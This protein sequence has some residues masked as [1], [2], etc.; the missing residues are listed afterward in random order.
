MKGLLEI[1]FFFICGFLLFCMN[2]IFLSPLCEIK[3]FFF[4]PGLP[5]NFYD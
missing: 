2:A 5:R 1:N 4:G 3:D